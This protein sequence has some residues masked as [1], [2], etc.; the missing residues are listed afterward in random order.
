MTDGSLMTDAMITH[1]ITRMYRLLFREEFNQGLTVLEFDSLTKGPMRC[2]TR[3]AKAYIHD[4]GHMDTDERMLIIGAATHLASSVYG[5][6]E[7]W[8]GD[9][10]ENDW[11]QLL[12]LNPDSITR[13]QFVKY[14]YALLEGEGADICREEIE[15]HERESRSFE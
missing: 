8:G 14:Q 15:R 13:K 3:L 5:L 12:G 1:A 4:H 6:E 2:A 9:V 11:L 7:E 10:H